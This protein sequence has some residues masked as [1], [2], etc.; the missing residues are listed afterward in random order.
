MKYFGLM[1]ATSQD[2]I[3]VVRGFNEGLVYHLMSFLHVS[4]IFQETSQRIISK[5][6]PFYFCDVY[7]RHQPEKDF[8]F[9][10]MILKI[11]FQLGAKFVLLLELLK[12]NLPFSRYSEHNANHI[13]P[14]CCHL[15]VIC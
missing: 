1:K 12:F 11:F 14:L 13:I 3:H 2:N 9:S 5:N 7:T 10:I 15:P 6:L 4:T 8:S